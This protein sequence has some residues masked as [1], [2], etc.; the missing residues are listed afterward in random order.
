MDIRSNIPL[1]AMEFVV[2]ITSVICVKL[3]NKVILPYKLLCIQIICGLIIEIIGHIFI[4][5]K[6]PIENT[7]C[8][9]VYILIEFYLMFGAAILFLK[10]NNRVLLS[11]GSLPFIIFMIHLSRTGFGK[12]SS[13]SFLAGGIIL[14]VFYLYLLFEI[15]KRT[16]ILKNIPEF[17]VCIG[18]IAYFGCTVPFFSLFTYFV[19]HGKEKLGDMLFK[20]NDFLALIRYLCLLIAFLLLNKKD[21]LHGYSV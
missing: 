13:F 11:F 1:Y 7:A 14:V 18:I 17:W 16:A 19:N 5:L 8:F 4:N 3:Y 12:F 21:K 15:S 9:N 20:L 2:L 6:R 10:K